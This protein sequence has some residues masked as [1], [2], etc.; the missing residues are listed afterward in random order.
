[1]ATDENDGKSREHEKPPEYE[2]ILAGEL[3]K[4]AGEREG[5]EEGFKDAK[6]HMLRT[7]AKE[8]HEGLALVEIGKSIDEKHA[9]LRKAQADMHQKRLDDLAILY[10]GPPSERDKGPP[11]PNPVL[12]PRF[13]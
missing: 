4:Q 7:A 5:Q 1:M 9:E 3:K 2:K 13:R 8:G 6:E 10:L 12:R 11:A